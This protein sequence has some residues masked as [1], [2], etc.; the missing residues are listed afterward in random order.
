M[1]SRWQRTFSAKGALVV[2]RKYNLVAM[3]E[4]DGE[5]KRVAAD[6]STETRVSVHRMYTPEACLCQVA[7]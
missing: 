1:P 5:M 2:D 3:A 7:P 4:K 6:A